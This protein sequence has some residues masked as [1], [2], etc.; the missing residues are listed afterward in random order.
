MKKIAFLFTLM[1]LITGC[2]DKKLDFDKVKQKIIDTNVYGEMETVN[3]ENIYNEYLIDTS[4]A[5]E[6]LY[7]RTTDISG[8]DLYIIVKVNDEKIK[9][10]IDNRF[11][12]L[13][14][15]SEMYNPE[16]NK[17]VKNRLET[18]YNGY[19]IYI[20]SD[21]NEKVLEAIKSN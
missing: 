1:L 3:N 19:N 17:K 16:G 9:E 12:S 2:N 6:I 15:T 20:V 21:N 4:L 11:E 5:D 7:Q 8:V 18:T 14:L 13:E 10:Q